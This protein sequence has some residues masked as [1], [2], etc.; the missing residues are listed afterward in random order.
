MKLAVQRIYIR[1]YWFMEMAEAISQVI[2]AASDA[3][4]W[5]VKNS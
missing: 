5:T 1:D 3:A 2:L 4:C